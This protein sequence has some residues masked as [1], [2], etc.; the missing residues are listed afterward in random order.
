M[1]ADVVFVADPI[2]FNRCFK[3]WTGGPVGTWMRVKTTELKVA[4]IAEAP[5]PGKPPRNRTMHNYATGLLETSIISRE[6]HDEP[7]G[8]LESHV[9]ALP[10]H[11]KFLIH[12]TSPYIIRPK[13]PGG[14]LRFRN[15]FGVVVY[16]RF[17]KHP[18][19]AKND[20]ASRALRR[21]F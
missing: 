21:V 18:G 4:V 11:A 7:S 15:R 17:V 20:F 16:A 12:G 8:D 13:K 6:H 1:A 14:L 5:G 2:A 10:E 19:I 3:S 9:I